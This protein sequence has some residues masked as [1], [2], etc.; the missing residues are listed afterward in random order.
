ME[1]DEP[2][3]M[4]TQVIVRGGEDT[5][6]EYVDVVEGAEFEIY[7]ATYSAQQNMLYVAQVVVPKE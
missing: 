4:D 5:V 2:M 3:E 6:F 7:D 1:A